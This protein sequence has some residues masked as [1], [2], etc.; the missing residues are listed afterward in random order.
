MHAVLKPWL[1]SPNAARS[2]APPAPT[3]TASY[4][5]SIHLY[6]GLFACEKARA[7]LLGGLRLLAA[8]R[9]MVVR[10][11]SQSL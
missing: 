1:A 3:T 10:R 5:W 8:A 4:S 11:D 7:A 9:S 2:P 6:A